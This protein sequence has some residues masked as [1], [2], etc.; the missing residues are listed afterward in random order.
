MYQLPDDGCPTCQGD[1]EVWT[2]PGDAIELVCNL[3][4][5]IWS[6][7]MEPMSRPMSDRHP[8]DRNAALAKY[9]EADLVP[10]GAA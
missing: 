1:L 2:G 4:G 5:C 3:L 6:T 8:A 9:P 7:D 10:V